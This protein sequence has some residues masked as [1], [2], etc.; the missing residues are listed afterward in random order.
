MDAIAG[1]RVLVAGDD[2]DAS[3]R[4]VWRMR[5]TAPLHDVGKIAIPDTLLL[6]PAA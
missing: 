4:T 6:K 5:H 3:D 2:A 1:M